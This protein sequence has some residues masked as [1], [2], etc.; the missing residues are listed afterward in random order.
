MYGPD[1]T[2]TA[3]TV[4]NE[5]HQHKVYWASIGMATSQKWK[6]I[7]R[8]G[9]CKLVYGSVLMVLLVMAGM[10]VN[11]RPAV[12]HNNTDR[13]D[14]RPVPLEKLSMAPPTSCKTNT[15]INSAMRLKVHNIT[16]PSQPQHVTAT[17][18]VT[19]SLPAI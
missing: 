14:I 1:S 4:D 7:S 10:Q 15:G 5:C 3:A 17:P 12:D 18:I 16:A 6:Q 11:L 19:H 9:E 2:R 8:N 13:Y